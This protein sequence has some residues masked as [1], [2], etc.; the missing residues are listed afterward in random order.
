[1]LTNEI[2][3]YIEALSITQEQKTEL[4]K[5]YDKTW[6]LVASG[7]I[8]LECDLH[9]ILNNN[10]YIVDFKSGFGSNEKGNLNRLL[11]V[12]SIYKSLQEKYTCMIFVR[13]ND[14]NNYFNTLKN[15]GVWEAY[16]G[17]EAYNKIFEFSGF[18]LKAWID[19]N[20]N[21]ANDFDLETANYF[22]EKKLTNYL[23]W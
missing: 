5:Y 15:S 8:Q 18:N 23:I 13:S 21:W 3:A 16:S 9:F 4:I 10:K 7:E 14:N 12:A 2:I 6:K 22:N 11:L 1:M 17:V 19:E 20:I